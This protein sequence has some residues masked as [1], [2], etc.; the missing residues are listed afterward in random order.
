MKDKKKKDSSVTESEPALFATIE[1]IQKEIENRNH[2]IVNLFI[3][4]S[5]P[6][7]IAEVIETLD[8]DD[9]LYLFRNCNTE[10]QRIIFL[11]LSDEMQAEFIENLNLPEVTQIVEELESDEITYLFS[12][13]DKDRAEEILNTIGPE[14]SVRIRTQLAYDENTAGRLMNLDFASLKVSDTARRGIIS[15]RKAA[16][17]TEDI[18]VIFVLD[19]ENHLKGIVK[20]KDLLIANPEVPIQK[21]MQPTKSIHYSMDQEEVANFFKKYDIVSAP[22]VDDH[23]MI[24]GRITIDDVLHVVEE[25]ATEDIYRMGGVSEEESISSSVW[26]SVRHRLLWLTMNLFIAMVTTSVVTFFEDTIQRLVVLASLMPIVAGMGGNAGTQAITIMVRNIATGEITESNLFGTIRKELLIGIINGFSVGLVAFSV[27]LFLRQD[28]LISLVMGLAMMANLGLA[29]FMGSFVPVVL[30]MLK[31]D[32]AIA[33]S[34]FVTAFTD[35]FGFF[36]FLGLAN[37]MIP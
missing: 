6:A 16:K 10:K 23:G 32:P 24:L 25:E 20:L 8:L 1:S 18:Y 22:V 31:I 37:I 35:M 11:N 29:G 21:I 5:H 36:C 4:F 9:A 12:D 17:E 28:F 30:R 26:S 13:M 27:T 19:E 7:D 14:D 33:S 3:N 2:Q 34:I 15:I